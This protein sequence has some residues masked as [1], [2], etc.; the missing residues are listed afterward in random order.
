MTNLPRTF[1]LKWLS[2]LPSELT[3]VTVYLPSSLGVTDWK[4][5]RYLSPSTSAITS[6]FSLL[7]RFSF[8]RVHD[9]F[10]FGLAS[11]NASKHT[12]SPG[13]HL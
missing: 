5:I 3:A 2:T 11:T 7:H 1:K 10:G 12:E 6:Q 13:I 4:T 8:P 9:T